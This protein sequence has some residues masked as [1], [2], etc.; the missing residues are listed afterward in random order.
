MS[1]FGWRWA[2]LVCGGLVACFSNGMTGTVLGAWLAPVLLLAFVM[3]SRISIGL[4]AMIGVWSV[5]GYVMFRGALPISEGA[6]VT[7]SLAGGLVAATPYLLHRIVAPQL[8]RFSGTMVFPT[9]STALIYV[10][11]SG[12][13]F[14]TWGHEAYTQIDVGPL[15]QIASAVGI[16]GIS[17]LIGWFAAAVVVF[18]TR[19][20]RLAIAAAVAFGFCLTSVFAFGLWRQKMSFEE[21]PTVRAAALSNPADM[22]DKFFEG[23]EKFSDLVCRNEKAKARWEK[24]FERS[25]TAA[26]AGAKV[27]V[28]YESA[29]Q[30]DKVIEGE[31]VSQA[32]AFAKE[33]GVYLIVGAAVVPRDPNGLLENKAMAFTPEGK[34]AFTYDKSKPVPGE[35]IRAGNGIIPTLDTPYGRLGAMICFDADFPDLSRQAAARGVDVLAVPSNDWRAITPLHGEM[36]RF[37]AIENGFSVVRATSNGLSIVTD[38]LGRGLSRVNSFDSPGEIAMADVPARRIETY[39]GDVDDLFAGFSLLAALGLIAVGFVRYLI[40]WHRQRKIVAENQA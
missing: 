39:Y 14:G 29:A 9:V 38:P 28:W 24:L 20:T 40:R 19:P 31:F 10:I 18:Q 27:I 23:C 3:A 15:A 37:R 2:V 12:T 32:K 1:K 16:W 21:S 5:A 35:P 4:V 6:Y 36:I 8:D 34:L 30:Y 26:Q 7:M 11:S 33:A 22:P 25:R 17:F 13:P